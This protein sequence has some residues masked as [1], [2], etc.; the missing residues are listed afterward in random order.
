M[1]CC[2]I[3]GDFIYQRLESAEK[4]DSENQL[5]YDLLFHSELEEPKTEEENKGGANGRV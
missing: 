1:G 4:E 2:G 3:S 5:M